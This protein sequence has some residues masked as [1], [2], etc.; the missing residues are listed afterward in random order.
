M[1]PPISLGGGTLG[2]L[3][4]YYYHAVNVFIIMVKEANKI[5]MMKCS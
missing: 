1:A 3:M 4:K 5:M 2:L